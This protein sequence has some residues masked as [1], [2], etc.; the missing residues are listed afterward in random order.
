[1]ENIQIIQHK[2]IYKNAN[3]IIVMKYDN[4]VWK[5]EIKWEKTENSL[6]S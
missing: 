6:I 1:M 5:G 2:N 3:N 4:Y